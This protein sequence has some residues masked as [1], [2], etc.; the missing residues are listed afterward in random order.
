VR[1]ALEHARQLRAEGKRGDAE[2]VW[3]GVE[4]LYR[5]DLSARAIL[6]EL[7]RDRGD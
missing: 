7:R 5:D 4:A 1:K 3:R 2:E 6:E